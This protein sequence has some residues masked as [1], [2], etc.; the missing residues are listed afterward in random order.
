MGAQCVQD[1]KDEKATV[2]VISKYCT[3]M[4]NKMSDNET[5]SIT[6]WEKTHATERKPAT[7]RQAGSNCKPPLENREI[8]SQACSLSAASK[9]KKTAGREARP[10][11]GLS[12]RVRGQ[13]RRVPNSCSSITNRLMKSRYSCKAPMIAFLVATW[14][15]SYSK[16]ISLM[17]CV[18]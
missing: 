7:R 18:S 2:E 17:R 5:Q 6:Q 4:N 8:T 14:P 16:Y 10:F 3:C 1:N 15:S 11:E 12:C 13:S 9:I